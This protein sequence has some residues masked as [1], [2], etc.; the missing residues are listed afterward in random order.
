MLTAGALFQR[1]E[2]FADADTSQLYG[3]TPRLTASLAPQRLFGLPVYGS[4]NNEFAYLP[5]RTIDDG[6]VSNDKSLG[7]FDVLPTMRAALSRLT[8]LTFNTS[9]SYRT[10]YYTRSADE[11]GDLTDEPLTRQY[12]TLRSDVIGPVLAKIWDTPASG[13]SE[14]MKHL[15]EPTF[16]LEFI[17]AIGNAD[18]VLTLADS[19]DVIKGDST[20]LTY[21]INNRLLYRART[22]D[23]AAGSTI[24]FLTIGVQ[25]TYYLTDRASLNDQQYVSTCL[26]FAVGRPV[27]RRLE[28]Q[29]HAQPRARCDDSF[30]VRRARRR[31]ARHDHAGHA[32]RYAAS[33]STINFSRIRRRPTSEP[34]E[35]DDLELLDRAC[36]RG[37][38][39]ARTR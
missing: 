19:S 5:Y 1:I 35:L 11:D 18:Q 6:E 23:G 9:A 17:P 28:R 7:R 14:R 33:S 15:I 8:Y 20:R 32:S 4:V 27:R 22:A 36:C 13:Y 31:A 2:T 24:Q 16:A 34:G 10:T 3:S 29:T 21:G 25:Q 26:P 12:L 38:P 30:R 39:G 37:R